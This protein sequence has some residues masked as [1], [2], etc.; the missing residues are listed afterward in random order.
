MP[1]QPKAFPKCLESENFMRNTQGI[2]AFLLATLLL[3]LA[4][5]CTK[6]SGETDSYRYRAFTA[7]LEGNQFGVAL[8]CD[9]SCE[10]GEFQSIRYN[11]PDTLQGME[12]T[13]LEDGS[14]RMEK[15]GLHTAFSENDTAFEGLL[16]PARALLLKGAD[17]ARPRSVRKLPTGRLLTLEPPDGGSVITVTLGEDGFPTAVSDGQCAFRVLSVTLNDPSIP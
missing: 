10:N 13:R 5:S 8:S 15:D 7:S 1:K 12:I 16:L 11:A 14:L 2:V 9:V 3:L 6:P 17:E 4:V